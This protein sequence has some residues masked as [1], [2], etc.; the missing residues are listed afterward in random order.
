MLADIRSG[1]KGEMPIE[2]LNFSIEELKSEMNAAAAELDFE[3]AA[4]IRDLMYE[5]EEEQRE[6]D[7]P[8]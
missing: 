1:L 5:L 6:I 3:R 8:L 7:E 2:I 4:M